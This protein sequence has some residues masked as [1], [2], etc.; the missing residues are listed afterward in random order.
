VYSVADG[1]LDLPRDNRGMETSAGPAL[2]NPFR[3]MTNLWWLFVISGVFWIV[4]ALVVLQFDEASITTVGVL[5]GIMFLVAGVQNFFIGSVAGGSMQWILWIFAVLFVIAGV[6]SLVRPEDTFAGVAD[7]LG[8][9]F[10]LVGVFWLVQAFAERDAND[11]WWFGLISG[12]A[13]IILAFWT[14]GQFF[15]EKQYVLLVFA[16][17]WALFHGVGDLIKAFQIRKLRDLSDLRA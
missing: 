14:G 7:I 8:F 4:V 16:G 3:Q 2:P 12:V 11:L 9:L 13:M 6:I 5:I 17:I 10:L 1:A 15:I